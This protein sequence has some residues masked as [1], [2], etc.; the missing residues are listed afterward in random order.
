MALSKKKNLK[1]F[2]NYF[3]IIFSSSSSV[4]TNR[5]ASLQRGGPVYTDTCSLIR[6]RI[7]ADFSLYLQ[8]KLY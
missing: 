3:L 7:T 2:K 8:N 5:E 4:L 1:S 6:S